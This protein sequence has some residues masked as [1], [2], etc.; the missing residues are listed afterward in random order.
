MHTIWQS[1]WSN[2]DADSWIWEKTKLERCKWDQILH[3]VYLSLNDNLNIFVVGKKLSFFS[4]KIAITV[5][6]V[7]IAQTIT[8]VPFT[9]LT[10]RTFYITIW[11]R[12]SKLTSS[13]R[14]SVAPE[15]FWQSMVRHIYDVKSSNFLL[16]CQ[17][18]TIFNSL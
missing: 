3:T 14:W 17:F 7:C 18:V 4:D 8:L 5:N 12:I 13:D 1:D 16:K 11:E 9:K 6:I 10:I 2:V 15:R